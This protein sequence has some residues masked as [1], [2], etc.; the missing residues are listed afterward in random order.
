MSPSQR[1][2]IADRGDAGVRLDRVLRR[3]LKDVP[4]ATR[5]RVQAWIAGGCVTVNDRPV[6]RVAARAALGDRVSVTM[7]DAPP[8]RVMCG[9][10]VALAVLYEDDHVVAVDKPAGLVVH[11][12]FKHPAGT[13][14]N[15]LLGHARTWPAGQRPSIVGRLDKLTSGVVLAAKS[16]D[17]HAAL[18]RAAM[19]KIYLALVYG[20]V[21]A[22]RG[23]IDLRLAVDSDRRRVVASD[24]VGAA[25]VT[26]FERIARVPA[27]RAG[28]SLLRCTL[29]TGRR[30]QIR[31]HLQARGWP[32]VG[33]PV[34]GEPRWARVDD[35][36]LA[37]A[38]R[39]F[40]RQALHAAHL[41]FVHPITRSLITI[42]AP[43]AK[44]F[45]GLV[46]IAG[47]KPHA[48]SYKP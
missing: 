7:P 34:Y 15:A 46:E 17:V 35:P 32:I 33:D 30:H 14:M 40:P 3:H 11:P 41:A 45:A 10:D 4:A 36:L 48:S 39:A 19:Q 31:A 12:T 2:L 44:D 6:R 37:A 24:D 23:T 27:P 29:E 5:T 8:R 26:R 42:D 21:P 20:R 47:L 13:L 1:T 18:Q 28:L 22:A 38:L 43:L 25:S 16:G 9:E